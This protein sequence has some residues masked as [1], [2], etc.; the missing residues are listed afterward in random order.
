M[1]IT[2]TSSDTGREFFFATEQ[3]YEAANDWYNGPVSK[4]AIV[5]FCAK[6]GVDLEEATADPAFR[7]GRK[8]VADWADIA[9][10]LYARVNP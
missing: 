9:M 6:H 10:E 3:A 1:S 7:D 5:E 2:I 4:A 8:L